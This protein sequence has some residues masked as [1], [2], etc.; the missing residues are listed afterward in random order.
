MPGQYSDIEVI[1]DKVES[2]NCHRLEEN[3]NNYNR[4]QCD[5]LDW[6]LE[7]QGTLLGKL[8]EAE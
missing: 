7:Q 3:K 6:I 4:M 2:Q 8:A 5:G 1:K